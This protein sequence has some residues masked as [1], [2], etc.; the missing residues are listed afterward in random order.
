MLLL[1][2]ADVLHDQRPSEDGCA[3]RGGGGPHARAGHPAQPAG[4]QRAQ[5]TPHHRRR[6][7]QD[8]QGVPLTLLQSPPS[9]PPAPG[10]RK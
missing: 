9:R 8:H 3:A 10:R 1:L 6:D 7:P 4:P 2:I 5:R